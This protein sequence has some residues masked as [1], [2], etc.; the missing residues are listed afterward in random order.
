MTTRR[1]ASE[2]LEYIMLAV[3][4]GGDD[5][6]G[7]IPSIGFSSNDDAPSTWTVGTWDSPETVKVG[8]GYTAVWVAKFLVGPGALALAEGNY[9]PWVKV[10]AGSQ[11]IVRRTDDEIVVF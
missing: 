9:R 8:E 7:G 4:T 5:P 10:V 11:Q 3:Q 1:I 2:S 6:S